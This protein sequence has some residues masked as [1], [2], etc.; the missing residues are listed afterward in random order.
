MG[1]HLDFRLDEPLAKDVAD[2]LAL[3]HVMMRAQTNPESC[4][5]KTGEDLVAAGAMTFAL[6]DQ[7]DWTVV[8][9]GALAPVEN[10]HLELKSMHVVAAERGTGLGRVL[11]RYMVDH[12]V[13]QGIVRLSLETGSGEDHAAARALYA[14]AGFQ[15]CP[16]FGTYTDDPLSHFMTQ[17]L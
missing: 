11:L 6:R 2:V 10:G 17:A 4:H 16:P 5:V 12:A 1:R 13:K 3:H 8:A 14:K 7:A 15:T 9:V